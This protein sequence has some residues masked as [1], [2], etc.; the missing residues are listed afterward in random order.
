VRA[1]P[2]D[3]VTAEVD[4]PLRGRFRPGVGGVEVQGTARAEQLAH[5]RVDLEV[6]RQR[7]ELQPLVNGIHGDVLVQGVLRPD[8]QGRVGP[9]HGR[10]V[11]EPAR[12]EVGGPARHRGPHRRARPGGPQRLRQIAGALGE[13]RAQDRGI[14]DLLGRQATGMLDQQRAG[15]PGPHR[16]FGPALHVT[17]MPHEPAGAPA[18]ARGH[19]D[20]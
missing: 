15:R 12:V 1:A 9:V 3:G 18:R 11:G 4:Q 19:R 17:E 13:P 10:L 14:V 8:G 6:H 2:G 5:P 16:R 20:G 7:A